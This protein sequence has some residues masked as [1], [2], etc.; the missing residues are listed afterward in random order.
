MFFFEKKKSKKLKLFLL[1]IIA[2]TLC[3]ITVAFISYRRI[4]NKIENPILSFQN[5]AS[6]SIKRVHQTSTRNGIKE[7]SLDASSAQHMHSEKKA[8]FKDLSVTFFLKDESEVY[9]TA[10][11]G[12]LKTDSND[13]VTNGNY[14]LKTENLY[15]EHKN[16]KIY[17][18]V[19]VQ[20]TGNSFHFIADSMT[21]DLMTKQTLLEGKVEGTFR[22]NVAL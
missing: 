16:R 10:D 5:Q 8:I 22:K 1:S 3:L 18:K 6:L 4:L 12:I 7:W 20:I 11:H 17:T 15:Y 2:I 21:F 13:I 19:P 14:K 9:L